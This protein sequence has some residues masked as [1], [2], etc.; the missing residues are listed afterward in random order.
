MAKPLSKSS[1]QVAVTG[2][3]LASVPG[4]VLVGVAGAGVGAQ[5]PPQ[6]RA[7]AVVTK[8]AHALSKPGIHRDVVFKGKTTNVYSYSVD[9][10]DTSRVV[11]EGADGKRTVGRLVGDKFV[12][13][14]VA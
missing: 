2:K 13:V 11:R 9:V 8:V 14:K 10:T 1:I 5:T 7:S 12:S 6:D 3:F 4:A